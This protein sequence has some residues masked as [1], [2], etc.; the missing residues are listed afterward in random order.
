M[1]KEF[2]D[3]IISECQEDTEHDGGILSFYITYKVTDNII[4]NEYGKFDDEFES[5]RVRLEETA[6]RYSIPECID[7]RIEKV[8]FY[9]NDNANIYIKNPMWDYDYEEA[10]WEDEYIHINIP[11]IDGKGEFVNSII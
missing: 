11:Y 10:N 9:S 8:V 1:K 6:I 3:K 5:V 4:T 2:L 7:Y